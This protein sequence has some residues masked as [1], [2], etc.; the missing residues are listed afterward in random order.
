MLHWNS[1]SL[2]QRSEILLINRKI[3][4]NFDI[5]AVVS[6]SRRWTLRP[7]VVSASSTTV[8]A[9]KDPDKFKLEQNRFS[10]GTDACTRCLGHGRSTSTFRVYWHNY[11]NI[12]EIEMR[13]KVIYR[14]RPGYRCFDC[15]QEIVVTYADINML[16]WH[17]TSKLHAVLAWNF[18]THAVF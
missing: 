11:K 2:E 15:V 4:P 7:K 5:S 6:L 3:H 10:K 17:C 9:K 16:Q 12:L 8:V 1:G 18:G 14:F 13:Q